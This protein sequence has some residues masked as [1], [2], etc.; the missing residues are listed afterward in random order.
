MLPLPLAF[1]ASL[2]WPQ[3]LSDGSSLGLWLFLECDNIA[4]PCYPPLSSFKP[5]DGNSFLL[6]LVSEHSIISCRWV[7]FS[8][9]R[10]DRYKTL[11]E[12]VNFQSLGFL[13]CK[14]GNI[15]PTKMVLSYFNCSMA[16]PGTRQLNDHY[17]YEYYLPSGPQA[18][19]TN[20]MWLGS[21][22]LN[23]MNL[24]LLNDSVRIQKWVSTRWPINPSL[25]TEG[26]HWKKNKNSSHFE[27]ILLKFAMYYGKSFS[28][29][30]LTMTNHNSNKVIYPRSISAR[31][32]C[33]TQI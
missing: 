4:P 3:V 1:F 7:Y 31:Q 27:T 32:S 29:L 22:I 14:M 15:I 28:K 12:V 24:L 10:S 26:D 2:L 23:S 30:I 33:L 11:K 17:Y 18:M 5:S 9:Q 25:F 6:V 16:V 8:C 19:I 20:G 21:I 13:S